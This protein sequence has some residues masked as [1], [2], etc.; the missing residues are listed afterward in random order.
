MDE[1]KESKLR[2][3]PNISNTESFSENISNFREIKADN[4]EDNLNISDI[5]E[6]KRKIH[7]NENSNSNIYKDINIK[8]DFSEDLDNIK[9]DEFN[10]RRSSLCSL[11][12]EEFNY[13]DLNKIN[14][15]K[16]FLKDKKETKKIKKEDLNNI[17]LPIFSCIYCS[18][19]II[20]FRHL[21]Q[22]IITNK[23]LFQTSVY[24]IRDINKL[25]ICNYR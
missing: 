13:N 8:E 3:K 2:E 14:N 15:K 20:A 10:Q 25:I 9:E 18:N 16:A 4:F 23:Y 1:Y 5:M 24:D 7:L 19:D 22:E 17:P 12:S 21:I 6:E 11:Q